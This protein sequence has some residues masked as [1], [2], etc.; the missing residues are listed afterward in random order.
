MKT[1][2]FNRQNT[3]PIVEGQGVWWH[4]RN[5]GPLASLPYIRQFGSM[6]FSKVRV[7]KN[8]FPHLNDGIEV[9]FVNSGKYNWIVEG[10]EV[11]LLPDDLSVT[12]PW[13]LNGSPSGKMDIG[14]ITW[15][16][17]KPVAYAVHTPLKLGTWTKLPNYFQESLGNMLTKENTVVLRKAK[18]FKKYFVELKKELLNPQSGYEIMVGNIIENFLIEL[19]RHLS[20]RLQQIEESDNFVE[21]L[22]RLILMDLNKKWIIEDLAHRFGMGKTKFTDEVRKLTGY[23]PASFIINLKIDRAI[24]MLRHEKNH[25][26]DI[27]YSCGFSSLQH[28]TTTFSNRI[29]V[30]PGKFRKS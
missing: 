8:M 29:G 13:Q 17:I 14:E 1:K 11:E 4:I 2:E 27:A 26:S 24:E 9:H 23:P 19:H 21:K 18:V 28:F 5:P 3:K 12:T 30:G 20:L 10:H 16:V 6:K 25:L 7:D 22:T 15:I